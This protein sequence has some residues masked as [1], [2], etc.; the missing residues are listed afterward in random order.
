MATRKKPRSTPAEPA[1][2][3]A[4]QVEPLSVLNAIATEASRTLDVSEILD[5]ALERMVALTGMDGGAVLLV[6]EK[7]QR[8]TLAAVH[9]FPQ[10]AKDLIERD[11]L[12]VGQ[13]IP[14]IAAERCQLLIVNNAKDDERELP[15]SG[16]SGS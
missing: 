5:L 10:A 15:L 6:D 16:R 8:M 3:H 11:P 4:Q 1:N 14:G 13:A 2:A 12:Q 7:T 9:N